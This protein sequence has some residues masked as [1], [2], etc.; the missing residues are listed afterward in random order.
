MILHCYYCALGGDH[1]TEASQVAVVDNLHKPLQA[2]MFSPLHPE[3]DP[4]PPFQSN[5]WRYM[6]HRACGKYPWPYDVDPVS[7]PSRILT[8]RGMVKIPS[9]TFK[10]PVKII[11]G[12]TTITKYHQPSPV[13]G[14]MMGGKPAILVS[15]ADQIRQI[16][17]EDELNTRSRPLSAIAKEVGTSPQYVSNVARKMREKS[18]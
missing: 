10:I 1:P 3:H 14:E 6:L 7:G 4:S 9:E 2:D 8:D 12:G 15:K 18:L 17:R 11:D 16:I 5:E 13:K